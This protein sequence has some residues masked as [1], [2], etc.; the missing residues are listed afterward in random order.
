MEVIENPTSV[1]PLAYSFS[2]SHTHTHILSLSLPF[3]WFVL[4]AEH[5]HT[6]F[7]SLSLSLFSFSQHFHLLKKFLTRFSVDEMWKG[8]RGTAHTGGERRKDPKSILLYR[9]T[10]PISKDAKIPFCETNYNPF[11]C[12][13]VP[14]WEREERGR[15]REK[16]AKHT[17]QNAFKRTS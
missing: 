16:C 13:W 14:G 12:V 6:F 7:Q 15:K 1:A 17:S 4:T 8:E 9:L 11:M 3:H 5:F 2:L 10:D